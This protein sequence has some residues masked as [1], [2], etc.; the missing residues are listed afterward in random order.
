MQ[1]F[2]RVDGGIVVEIMSS[3][4]G[5]DFANLF[6]PDLVAACHPCGPDVSPGWSF[7]GTDFAPAPAVT[8]SKE[9]LVAYAATCRRRSELGGMTFNGISVATDA[10]SQTKV[11]GARV[12]ANANPAFTTPW[13]GNDGV[14]VLLDATAIVALSDAVLA[15]VQGGYVTRA[16]LLDQIE[17]GE[18]TT[19]A[20]IDAAFA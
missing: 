8:P 18:I 3:P 4:D 7:D 12:A 5:E 6:H 15:H 20:E 9:Q 16:A 1:R 10:E 2:A 11:L 17:A 14:P 19:F 13:F